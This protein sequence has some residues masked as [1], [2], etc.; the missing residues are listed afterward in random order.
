MKHFPE[1]VPVANAWFPD[2]PRAAHA[3]E[4][5]PPTKVRL[6]RNRSL[7]CCRTGQD[8]LFRTHEVPRI[9]AV[10]DTLKFF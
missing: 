7:P 8:R 3:F 1:H 4:I 6:R 2:L 10:L 9:K 5:F